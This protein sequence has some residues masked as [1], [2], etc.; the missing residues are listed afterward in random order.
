AAGKASSQP[1]VAARTATAP[2]RRRRGRITNGDSGTRGFWLAPDLTHALGR[3]HEALLV[4]E[5]PF[6]LEPDRTLHHARERVIRSSL[7]D[8]VT[9]RGLV[10]GE[11][12]GAQASF[13][14]QPHPVARGAE[15]LA[16]RRDEA[17]PAG[18]PVREPV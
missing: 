1:P 15:R 3:L 14:G 6:L 4:D 8:L 11:K 17:D 9:Q 13:G 12:T 2:S 16:D 7:T 5:V 10:Q 18:R